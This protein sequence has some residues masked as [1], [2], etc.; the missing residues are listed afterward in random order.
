MR[1]YRDVLKQSWSIL[2][3]YAWLWPFGLLAAL[4]GVGAEYN[5]LIA[6]ADRIN[7][8]A[9]F[10]GV[11]K[12]FTAAGG[13]SQAWQSFLNSFTATPLLFV[14]GLVL[15]LIIALLIVW[16]V[17]VAQATLIHAVGAID[18]KQ[19]TSF[20][21]A[22]EAGVHSFWPIFW[23][24]L[25]T[26]FVIYI[27]LSV[28]FLP[29]LISF[30][31]QQT[32]SWNFDSLIVISFLVSVPLSIVV[33]FILKYAAIYIVLEKQSW[34]RALAN[35]VNLFGRNWLVSLEMAGLMFVISFALSMLVYFLIPAEFILQLSFLWQQFDSL[36]MIR[37]IRSALVLV[38]TGS[39]YA[40]F[41][42]IAWVILFR[43][44]NTGQAVA[45][46][47][48]LT[49]DIPNYIHTWVSPPAGTTKNGNG[50]KK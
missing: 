2:W 37:V 3:H 12:S 35:A 16:L 33:S 8:Q 25:L 26:K 41:Q 18:K 23:L 49:D 44:I 47:N 29:F 32:A 9:D 50:R 6:A 17:V 15:L 20:S 1:I 30:L 11:L 39:L 46:L 4:S 48:R 21:Q 10:L 22:A 13:L 19:S 27:I 42:Y 5:S 7:N 36:T 34:W 28:A 38:I 43:F 40:T 14:W 24:N 45:K 31:A